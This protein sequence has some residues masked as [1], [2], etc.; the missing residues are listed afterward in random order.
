MSREPPTR[1]TSTPEATGYLRVRATGAGGSGAW[2]THVTGSSNA[3]EPAPEPTADPI[4]VSFTIGEDDGYPMEPDDGDDEETAMAGVNAKMVVSSNYNIAITP[5]FIEGAAAVN[6]AAGDNN[7]PFAYVD[8]NALQSDV[9]DGGATFMVQRMVM[10]A[11]QEMEPTGDVAYVACGPFECA[12]GDSSVTAPAITSMDDESYANWEPTLEISYGW[13]D[14]DV[15]ANG[16][17]GA[18]ANNT[19]DDGIDLGWV[20]SSTLGMDVKHI[21]DGVEDGRNFDVAGPDAAGDKNAKAT[22]L[23]VLVA[24]DPAT[25]GADEDENTEADFNGALVHCIVDGS[26]D[27]PDP[28]TFTVT[29]DGT[30]LT[31]DTEGLLRPDECFK[32]DAKP[33]WFSGYSVEFTPM[34][35]GVSWG[36]IDWFKDLEYEARTFEASDFRTDICDLLF[37]DEVDRALD[38]DW[39][40]DSFNTRGTDDVGGGGDDSHGGNF[41]VT[42]W[43]IGPTADDDG[44]TD[45][46]GL[47]ARQFKTLWFD[48]DLDGD[49][50]VKATDKDPLA[51]RLKGANDL[52]G[53]AR[54]DTPVNGVRATGNVTQIWQEIIDDDN[55]PTSDFGKIDLI[56]A[57]DDPT[58]A[59]NETTR[60]LEACD[61]GVPWR[62]STAAQTAAREDDAADTGCG[63]TATVE[64]RAATERTPAATNSD[65]TAD[66]MTGAQADEAECTMDDNGADQDAACDA[67]L[68]MDFDLLFV[69]GTFGCETRRPITVTCTWDSTADTGIGNDITGAADGVFTADHA[70]VGAKCEVEVN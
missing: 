28:Y 60:A 59:D 7:M 43:N 10:G 45:D 55:D 52:Y 16:A 65:G 62:T 38:H 35:D 9:I 50:K 13:V 40:N 56:S 21:F 44:T 32:I 68:V 47:N 17:D 14:N 1:W 15:F 27:P 51:Y 46:E 33:D 49:L 64:G 63:R 19:M 37:E 70:V 26:T 25:T 11:S 54:G 66:N 31:A 22:A 20:T 2:S 29:G 48:D 53:P 58:T 30:V 69:D 61:P 34:N 39:E 41:Y 57:D 8:W 42:T 3:P 23:G 36:E 24:D 12:S 67:E 6:V 18:D 4:D 5:E